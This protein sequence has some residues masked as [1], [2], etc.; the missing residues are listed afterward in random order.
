M[1]K[2]Y[3][4]EDGSQI[5]PLG[6]LKHFEVAE[7]YSDIR[8][9]RVNA[10]GGAEVGKVRELLVDVDTMRTRYLDVRLTPEISASPASRDVLVPISAAQ[11]DEGSNVVVVPLTVERVGLLPPYDGEDGLTRAHE[12]EVR[13]HFLA[14][15]PV[16]GAGESEVRV[17][18]APDDTVVRTKGLDGRD[19]I[20]IRRPENGENRAP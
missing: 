4:T 10:A 6:D 5:A 12:F 2:R 19:E 7:G 14:A 3:E 1:T 9:W 17:P 13:R 20:V 11:I 16:V 18:V 8:G 15:A